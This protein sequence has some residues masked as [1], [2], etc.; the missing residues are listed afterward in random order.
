MLSALNQ[1]WPIFWLLLLN[2]TRNRII[3]TAEA[4]A[5]TNCMIFLNLH[6]MSQEKAV[7]VGTAL[8]YLPNAESCAVS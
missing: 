2:R 3:S 4:G 1:T 5:A 8:F 6:S 7:G